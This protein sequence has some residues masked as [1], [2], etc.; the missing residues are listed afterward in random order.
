MS[1]QKNLKT[2]LEEFKLN[3]HQD[4]GFYNFYDWF[5][6]KKSLE[7]RALKLFKKLEK[8]SNSNKINLE[9]NYST[10]K[11]NCPMTGE[12]YDD[13]RICEIETGDVIF[14]VSFRKDFCEIWGKENDFAEHILKGSWEDVKN[15]FLK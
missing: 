9:N 15:Y 8:I 13:F 3:Q 7:K 5:C 1:I 14:N 2:Q 12:T 4:E 6:S 10:F 11:N